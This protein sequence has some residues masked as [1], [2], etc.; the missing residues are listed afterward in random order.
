M[1][2]TVSLHLRSRTSTSMQDLLPYSMNKDNSLLQTHSDL[3]PQVLPPLTLKTMDVLLSTLHSYIVRTWCDAILPLT[4]AQPLAH[5]SCPYRCSPLQIPAGHGSARIHALI[6]LTSPPSSPQTPH[7]NQRYCMKVP[8]TIPVDETAGKPGRLARI[9]IFGPAIDEVE[10]LPQGPL[11]ANSQDR[12]HLLSE[13]QWGLAGAPPITKISEILL[14]IS[15][16]KPTYNI[17][18]TQCY[19]FVRAAYETFNHIYPS[20]EHHGKNSSKALLL[21]WRGNIFR[22]QDFQNHRILLQYPPRC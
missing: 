7:Q 6:H 4:P 17:F 13:L 1:I 18:S 9:G 14:H 12:H 8:H 10:I 3:Y 21:P 20:Y 22:H 19:F 5:Q 2:I 15:N 16:L 11:G